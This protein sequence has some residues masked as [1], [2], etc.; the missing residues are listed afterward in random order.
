MLEMHLKLIWCEETSLS[1][2]CCE[3]LSF[4]E[5]KK[6]PQFTAC[7]CSQRN[8]KPDRMN[9]KRQFHQCQCQF[10]QCWHQTSF[11]ENGF[12]LRNVNGRLLSVFTDIICGMTALWR[13]EI[14][15]LTMLMF[16]YISLVFCS[17]KRCIFDLKTWPVKYGHPINTVIWTLSMDPLVSVLTGFEC[18]TLL[19]KYLD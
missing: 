6:N 15:N 5:D 14:F 7:R 9:W 18:T 8:S 1:T 2:V 12:W 11:A 19:F 13:L 10:H 17:H 3:N 4:F 16:C